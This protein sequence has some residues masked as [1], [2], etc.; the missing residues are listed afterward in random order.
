MRYVRLKLARRTYIGFALIGIGFFAL[1]TF[2]VSKNPAPTSTKPVSETITYSTSSPSEAKPANYSWKG[3][4]DDPK[5]I[6]LPSIRAE[7]YIQN[8]GVDQYQQVAVPNNVHLAGWFVKSNRPGDPGLSIIDGHVDGKTRPG[9]FEQLVKLQPGDTY[10]V[11]LGNG[12][13]KRYK[14]VSVTSV[15]VSEAAAT[16]Y[17]YDPS[18]KS[19]LNL[20]TCTGNYTHT[21]GYDMRAIAKAALIN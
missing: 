11:E 18:I 21:N 7:G 20:I 8:V 15:P 13:H 16:L 6:T 3:S 14:V 12:S 2:Y 17:A 1:I 5:Y 9:I 4:R 10:T 19:Q